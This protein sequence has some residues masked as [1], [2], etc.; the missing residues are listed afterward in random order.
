MG[1]GLF[2]T[3][4]YRAADG[5]D[6]PE[7]WLEK[8][9]TWLEGREEEPLVACYPGL[10]AQEEPCLAMVAHPCAEEVEFSVPGKGLCQVVAKTSTVGPGYHVFLCDLLRKL[11]LEFA[12]AW[13]E[14]DEQEGTGDETGYFHDGGVERLRQEM[15]KWLGALAKEVLEQKDQSD[16]TILVAMPMGYRFA[17]P[18]P[19]L[20]PLGPRDWEWFARVQDDPQQGSD[21]FAWWE[22]GATA[23]FF[24]GKALC[25][26]TS[27]KNGT[28]T[29]RTGPRA[30]GR[31]TFGFRR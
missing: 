12:I 7:E 22:E 29:E 19:V 20:T 16:S 26:G 15:G 9:A 3:G 13:D 6:T 30:V 27:R 23:S 21:F 1:L 28:M 8:V 4:R 2:L 10:N 5:P 31:A 11:G 24:L 17:F 25:P 14:P 18:G